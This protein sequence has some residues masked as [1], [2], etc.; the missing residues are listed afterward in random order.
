[1]CFIKQI[2]AAFFEGE[3]LG[4]ELHHFGLLGGGALGGDVHVLVVGAHVV[5]HPGEGQRA[6]WREE[7]Q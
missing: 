6:C 5:G 4:S 2:N 7:G 1:M 3:V